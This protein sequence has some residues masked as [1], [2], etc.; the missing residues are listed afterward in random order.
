MPR[1]IARTPALALILLALV[2]GACQSKADRLVYDANE[3]AKK[4]LTQD[5]NT[6]EKMLEQA[7]GMVA[8]AVQQDPKNLNGWKLKAQLDEVLNHQDDAVVDF[9]QASTLDPADQKLMAKARYYRSLKQLENSSDQALA[10]I[11]AGKIEDGIRQLK[12]IYNSK[13]RAA[14][15]KALVAMRAAAP[16]IEKLGDQQAADK[17]FPDALATYEQEVRAFMLIQ[18]AEGKDSIDPAVNGVL[19]K[20]SD[21]AS[22]GGTPDAT[23]R[24]LNDVLAADPENKT[25]NLELAQVYLKRKPP[26]YESAADLEERGGAPDADVKKLRD[27]AKKHHSG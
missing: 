15:A 27:Q 4:A 19:K 8:D 11:K 6:R 21:A 1:A 5:P 17:K 14:Q 13:N 2:A 26:D 3:T 24:I 10:D 22:A 18:Q 12:D 25:A 7:R 23:F 9:D 20:M 16:D